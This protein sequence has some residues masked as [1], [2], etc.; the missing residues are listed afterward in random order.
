MSLINDVL[1]LIR[2]RVDLYHNAR[3]CGDWRINEHAL[4][5]TCFHMPTQGDCLLSVP[6]E[7]EWHL[8]SGDVVIF[9]KELPHSMTPSDNLEGPQQHLP[10][11]DSQSIPGTSMVCGAIEFQHS[12]GD[13][14]IQLLPRVLIV[15]GERAKHW[16]GPLTE[17]IVAE[18]LNGVELDSPVL[19]RLCELLVVYALRYHAE[20]EHHESSIFAL[21]AHPKLFKAVQAIHN[22]PAHHWQLSTL[23]QEAAMSRTRFSELFTQ[24]AGMTA[25]HYLTWWRMQLAWSELLKGHSV[26]AVASNVGYQSEA[27]FA[28]AFKK[29]FG[30]T[31]GSVRTRR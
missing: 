3:V 20:H 10:I 21:Y 28:R 8:E 29:V 17:L 30:V 24:V 4:G 7:G 22:N 27:A 6:G 19:N 12:G 23:A 1:N 31:V 18:S 26:E 11:A 13:Q 9:P 14:L 5:A 2:L 15:R 16:L 25:T